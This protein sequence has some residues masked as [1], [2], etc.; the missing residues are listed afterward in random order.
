MFVAVYG[1]V[2]SVVIRTLCI[3]F[4]SISCAGML[5]AVC[6]SSRIARS[7]GYAAFLFLFMTIFMYTVGYIFELSSNTAETIFLSL[8]IEYLGAPLIAVFW[9]LFALYYNNYSIKNKAVMALL[10]IVPITTIVMLYTNEHHYFHYKTFIIDTSGPFPVAITQKGW[11]Y[12]ADFVYKMIVAFAGLALFAF[13]YGKT[14]GYRRRQAKTIFIGALSLWV[15]NFLQTLGIAPYGIDIEPFILSAALPLS[16][17]AMSRLRMFDLVPIA[18][19]KVFKTMSASV[20]VLDERLRVVDFNDSAGSI[21]PA[22]SD[23][24]IGKDV[25]AVF[26]EGS[27]LDMPAL[28]QNEEAEITLP[29]AGGMR[30]YSVSCARVGD[31]GQDSGLIVSLYDIT[32][33][34]EML[35]KMHRLASLDALTQVFSRW[36]FMDAFQ[37]EIERCKV[38]GG[39][40]SLILLDIDHFKQ[41]NDRHGHL[42]GDCVLRTVTAM[43][44]QTLGKDALLGRYGGEEF[45]ILLPGVE[46]EE[47]A[48]VAES[49][50]AAAAGAE[51]TLDE[52]VVRV[53]ISLGVAGVVFVPGAAQGLENA[54]ICDSLIL[55]ADTALYRA[56]QEGRNR[57]CS[58]GLTYGEFSCGQQ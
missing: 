43:L 18:R 48:A 20:I 26:P 42:T 25:A 14:T 57:V 49:L 11:W 31:T 41:V 2:Y 45:S 4:L 54:K 40:L 5:Y 33:S 9:F 24:A 12:Y 30:F 37:R 16:G 23:D 36:Y 44:R 46:Q 52:T 50:R 56:K 1:K 51:T 19:D 32:E 8:K 7:K 35:K 28:T 15:G 34:K 13:S 29:V 21:L 47:A 58:V 22:L 55:A 3:L 10:F 17:F 53:T 39:S 27:T 6:Y 38:A